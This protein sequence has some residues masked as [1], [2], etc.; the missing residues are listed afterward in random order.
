[1][2]LDK[3]VKV[4]WVA[5]ERATATWEGRFPLLKKVKPVGVLSKFR[6]GKQKKAREL[7]ARLLPAQ[8]GRSGKAEGDKDWGVTAVS[9]AG[10][11]GG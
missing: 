5:E 11:H 4:C 7:G 3:E 2:A 6:R 1:M 10:E 9:N 8:T